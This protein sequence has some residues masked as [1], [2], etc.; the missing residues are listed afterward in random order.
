[1]SPATVKSGDILKLLAARHSGEVFVAECKP[2]PSQVRGS[3][4]FRLDAWV[5]P[6]SWAH[7]DCIGYE[8]KVSRQDFLRD[9]KWRNYLPMCNQLYFVAPRGL[10]DPSELGDGVGLLEASKNL[11]R[12][13]IKR[14]AAHREVEIPTDLFRYVLMC[15]AQISRKEINQDPHDFWGEWLRETEKKRD[16]GWRVRGR[17]RE[18]VDETRSENRRLK[19]ENETYAE[20]RKMLEDAGVNDRREWS[21]REKLRAHLA[22]QQTGINEDLR[23]LL[24]RTQKNIGECI[25]ELAPPRNPV[26]HGEG[27]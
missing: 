24:E 12:L 19:I 10:I 6:R 4:P 2:G 20:L 18:I 14:K 25:G 3:R 8:I 11:K 17:V 5:M 21:I 27:E 13:M 26:A 7:P 1:M 16:L 22:E 9:D 23:R 15:R